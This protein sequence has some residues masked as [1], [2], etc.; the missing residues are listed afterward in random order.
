VDAQSVA[1]VVGV[2]GVLA[3]LAMPSSHRPG[4]EHPDYGCR[5]NLRA[6]AEAQQRFHAARGRFAVDAAELQ[7]EPSR[8]SRL[9]VWSP[10]GRF[11]SPEE[12]LS[13][14]GGILP[15]VDYA[16]PPPLAVPLTVAGGAKVG[17]GVRSATAACLADFGRSRPKIYVWSVSTW[18][19]FAADGS[20]IPA[21]TP[22]L[23][24]VER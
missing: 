12:S 10:S 14:A 16:Q 15:A 24:S 18:P 21:D 2:I 20:E 19:R 8:F 6:W 4:H 9:Y 7:F 3:A 11:A 5:P 1:A 17:I 13:G 22:H 23:E